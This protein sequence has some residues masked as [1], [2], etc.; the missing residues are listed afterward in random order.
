MQ[1]AA[2]TNTNNNNNNNNAPTSA[3]AAL[4]VGTSIA[5]NDNYYAIRLEPEQSLAL[6][7]W[8]APK[9]TL[10]WRDVIACPSITLK[11]CVGAGVPVDRLHRMQTDIREWIKHGKATVD[12]CELM[13]PWR[14][15]PFTD[16]GCQ[17]LG[18]L[19]VYRYAIEPQLLIDAGVTFDA[20]RSQRGLTPELMIM[21]KYSVD[22][23]IRL[24]LTADFLDVIGT[25]HWPKL[26]GTLKRGDVERLIRA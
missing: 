26:F 2:A 23:W 21:L 8:W 9:R 19:I 24:G 25:E 16:L 6:Y 5:S 1:S 12:E 10:T 4:A 17:S 15:D 14:P 20:L 13:K 18:D 11:T 3:V 22:D 7:G